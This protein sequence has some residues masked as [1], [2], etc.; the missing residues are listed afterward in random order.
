MMD[1]K[2]DI[3]KNVCTFYYTIIV[4]KYMPQIIPTQKHIKGKPKL[5]NFNSMFA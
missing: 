3:E 4:Y 1:D 2:K 5:F